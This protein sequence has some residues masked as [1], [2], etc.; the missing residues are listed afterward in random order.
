MAKLDFYG[1]PIWTKQFIGCHSNGCHGNDIAVDKLGNI[2]IAGSFEC[3]SLM[4]DD[5]KIENHWR[6]GEQ[7]F[8]VNI[9]SNG[10]VKWAKTPTGTTNSIPQI[11]IGN[12]GIFISTDVST[13]EMDFG[14][15]VIKKTAG[16]NYGSPFIAKYD[17]NGEIKWAKTINS[18][19][20]GEG[21]PRDIVM[22][23]DDNIYL[24]GQ[25][26]GNFGGTEMDFY[27]EKY[28]QI[29]NLQWNKLYQTSAGEYG[30][31]IGI[32]NFGNAYIVGYS[33]IKNFIGDGTGD[34]PSSVGIA[35]LN[36]N[37]ETRLRP[38]RPI[39]N[40]LFFDC[41]ESEV[42]SL[43]ATGQNIKWYDTPTL[44]LQVHTGEL[45]EK[46]FQTTDT[47]YVTQTI[48]NIESWPKE[49]I[50][51]KVDL[52]NEKVS[53]KKDT[54]SVIPNKNFSYQWMYNGNAIAGSNTNFYLPKLNGKYSV[55]IIAGNCS[56]T[57]D[58]IFERP[59]RPETDSLRYVC[60]KEPIGTL[61][62]KGENVI[63]YADNTYNDTLL[64]GNQYSPKITA[65]KTLYVRQTLNGV[66]SYP[67][68]VIVKFSELKDS[69]IKSGPSQLLT[70]FNKKF[71]Y[72]WYYENNLIEKADSNLY[73]PIKNGLYQVSIK[74]S[75][76][77]TL[78]SRY[79]VSQPKI[80]QTLYTVCSNESMPTL[81]AEG[82]NLYW[83][84]Y[85]SEKQAYDTVSKTNSYTPE[86][87]ESNYIYLMQ[88]DHGFSSYPIMIIILKANFSKLKFFSTDFNAG[89]EGK[90]NYNY[91]YQWFFNEETSP[92]NSSPFMYSP[93]FGK[94]KIKVSLGS[95]CDT[96][97]NCNYYPK[98]DSINYICS[99]SYP[100]LTVASNNIRWFSDIK[101]TH[102]I[103]Y[104]STIYPNLNGKD[105][106]FY[107]AQFKNNIA[108]WT[109]KVK[110]VYPALEKLNIIQND[111]ALV[112]DNPKQY[113]KYSW[114]FEDSALEF[115]SFYCKPDKQ[116]TYSVS[117][118]AGN[119][120]VKK[121]YSYIKT[122]VNNLN[123]S[124]IFRVYPN[125][126]IDKLTIVSDGLT[127][128]SIQL[129]LYSSNGQIIQVTRYNN[130]EIT[131]DISSLKSG[132]Y[133]LELRTD[134]E[135]SKFKIIKL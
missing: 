13:S 121:S 25:T 9:T 29:G 50:V 123:S 94:Y 83:M 5:I 51:F 23:L 81:T 33:Q 84:I 103:S 109:G 113:F 134:S 97:F 135:L 96:V 98:Y 112:V 106:T 67:Q 55:K 57:L 54:L 17:F 66:A 114:Q 69:I 127:N 125:P 107:V 86:L 99:N 59:N 38:Y 45:F 16:G 48:N 8:I 53:Y 47:L 104:N 119:C 85:R 49:V 6:W 26:F 65:N 60:Y 120:M 129:K 11:T 3:D 82:S 36:T 32:D 63:W 76:C 100:Q 68:K 79:F 42:K 89:F 80:R 14:G 4:I 124:M 31:G 30:H 132:I 71:K 62:A 87:N 133:F 20:G 41:N 28:D 44:S 92:S 37:S 111:S 90:D 77:S 75:I 95:N 1:D 108:T 40:R 115:K 19:H 56:K 34:W 21:T 70:T 110:A 101:L 72:Q 126:S 116:G 39:V 128:K 18:Y 78:L 117:I 131:I 122:S 58:Y 93:Y 27:I 64:V 102:L 88:S 118:L 61:S 43:Q 24:I 12:S 15:I 35:K 7:T 2:F 73:V 52:S 10:T 74:D 105:S 46:N 130:T 22:D 91:T